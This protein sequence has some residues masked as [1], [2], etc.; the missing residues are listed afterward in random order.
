MIKFKR[1]F[2]LFS[3]Y[4][5]LLVNA[6]ADTKVAYIDIEYI[7][8]NSNPG[9]NLIKKLNLIEN[10]KKE[11]F[12]SE[13]I[14][15]KEEENKIIASKS[16]ITEEQLK[17]DINEFQKKIE[18]YKKI[19]S[20]EINTLKKNRNSELSKLLDLINPIIKDYMTDNS[21]SMVIDKKNIYIADKNFDITE[22]IIDIIN[23]KIK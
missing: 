8:S 19:K 17:K 4:I 14:K 10:E 3:S 7:L 6:S 22:N 2:I 9:K 23:K 13:E 1:I 18:N 21:I 20:D 5:F 15:L 11:K 16:I 12:N